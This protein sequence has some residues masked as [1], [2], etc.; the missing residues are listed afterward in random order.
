VDPTRL[1]LVTSAM[2]RRS[3]GFAVAHYRSKNHLNKPNVRY[4]PSCM[5]A[6]VRVGCRQRPLEGHRRASNSRPSYRA[7]NRWSSLRRR[8][9]DEDGVF[10][11]RYWLFSHSGARAS[12]ASTLRHRQLMRTSTELRSPWDRVRQQSS[13]AYLRSRTEGAGLVE[14]AEQ[15]VRREP[16]RQGRTEL[17]IVAS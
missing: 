12:L 5:F 3:E 4:G 11:G 7:T 2:G 1:E 9:G 8:V 17:G 13:L 10:L 15:Q 16:V 14:R 6:G